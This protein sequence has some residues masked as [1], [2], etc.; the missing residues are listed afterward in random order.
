[1]GKSIELIATGGNFLNRA[2]MAYALR[3][4][5]SKWNAMKLEGFCKAKQVVNKTSWQNTDW[6]KIFTNSTA[7]RGLIVKICKELKK[8]ITIKPNNPVKK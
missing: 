1:M 7:N 4:R 5:I 2:P 3:S 8:L 6:D